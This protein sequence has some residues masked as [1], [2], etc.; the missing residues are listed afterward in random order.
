MRAFLYT[1]SPKLWHR[2]DGDVLSIQLLSLL[3]ES[4]KLVT[5]TPFQHIAQ[6][7]KQSR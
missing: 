2:E 1:W 4:P 3:C 7:I 6:F 5:I